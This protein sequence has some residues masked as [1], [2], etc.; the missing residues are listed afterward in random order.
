MF[1]WLSL[2]MMSVAPAKRNAA[3]SMRMAIIFDRELSESDRQR[4][5]YL[6]K[7]LLGQDGEQLLLDDPS[8]SAAVEFDD[9]LQWAGQGTLASVASVLET[10][11]AE[12]NVDGII[13]MGPI[14]AKAGHLRA[15]GKA[16]GRRG[17]QK[18]VFAASVWDAEVQGLGRYSEDRSGLRN[19]TY[20]AQSYALDNDIHSFGTL[21]DF[22]HAGII[23]DAGLAETFA[24][25]VREY[26]NSHSDQIMK[27]TLFSLKGN[28]QEL[29]GRLGSA[30]I[31]VKAMFVSAL[32]GLNEAEH[33]VLLSGLRTSKMPAFSTE[34]ANHAN[35]GA[36]ASCASEDIDKALLSNTISQIHSHLNGAALASLPVY[37]DV[38][39]EMRINIDTAQSLNI[40]PSWEVMASAELIGAE[41]KG[42]AA[43]SATDC[44]KSISAMGS[45]T[46]ERESLGSDSTTSEVCSVAQRPG[47]LSSVSQSLLP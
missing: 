14:G 45:A 20:S 43:L 17:L 1:F 47:L 37:V 3:K 7:G 41:E 24:V 19:F 13:L 23:V 6:R 25:D 34:D 36:F 32:P 26:I 9:N 18:P 2:G 30:P 10:A 42:N 38:E 12:R 22:S 39:E 4:I 27:T 11:L 16:K 31:D 35:D 33:R 21:V 40:T 28:G 46:C 44:Q 29:L 8:Q 15:A 5:E